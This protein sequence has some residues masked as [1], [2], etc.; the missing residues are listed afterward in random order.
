MRCKTAI[1]VDNFVGFEARQG[2]AAEDGVVMMVVVNPV[3]NVTTYEVTKYADL[4]VYYTLKSAIDRYNDE[5]LGV[6][7]SD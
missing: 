5:L 7:Y 1:C 3:D 4:W 6:G 2:I